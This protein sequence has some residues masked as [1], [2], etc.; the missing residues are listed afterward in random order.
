MD[1]K[2]R[3]SD[4]AAQEMIERMAAAGQENAWDRLEKQM[5]QCGFGKNGVCCRICAMG[6]CRVSKKA[7]L[8]VCGADVDTIVARNFLRAVAAGVSAHSDHGRTVAKVFL[9]M[10]R[11]ETKDYKVKDI[12]KLNKL[13]AELG[14]ETKDRSVNEIAEDIGKIALGEFGKYEGTQLMAK[15]APKPRQEH[16]RIFRGPIRIFA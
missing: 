13:A 3:S 7:S 6:P 2:K 4:E 10:A 11:G 8:G 15:R 1:S 16:K 12:V 14:V 9:S 5:P